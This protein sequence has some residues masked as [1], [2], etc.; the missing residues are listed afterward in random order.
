MAMAMAMQIAERAR[1][2]RLVPALSAQVLII[3]PQFM[4]KSDS[5]DCMCGSC[6]KFFL[7]LVGLPSTV[8]SNYQTAQVLVEYIV[9]VCVGCVVPVRKMLLQAAARLGEWS[10]SHSDSATVARTHRRWHAA[11]QAI[12]AFE[13]SPGDGSKWLNACCCVM[14]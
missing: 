8:V 1:Q 13:S 7:V 2:M 6:A 9:H 4:G 11:R 5:D 3:R 12:N 14:S 10:L